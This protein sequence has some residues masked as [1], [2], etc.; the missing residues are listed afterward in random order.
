[1]TSFNMDDFMAEH[2]G[3]LV[4]GLR[5]FDETGEEIDRSAGDGKGVQLRVLD[6]KKSI[7]KRER[8]GGA[9]NPPGYAIDIT[10]DFRMAD[11]LQM[12]FR[13]AAKLAADS[14]FLVFGGRSKGWQ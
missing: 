1:M 12:L 14:D 10:F 13:L 8:T 4:G 5:P 7:V 9:E 3:Y 2:A 6:D 11:K